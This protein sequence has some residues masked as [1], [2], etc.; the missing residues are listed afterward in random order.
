MDDHPSITKS[1]GLEQNSQM[2]RNWPWQN[3]RKRKESNIWCKWAVYSQEKGQETWAT[4]VHFTF[5][6]LQIQL[7]FSSSVDKRVKIWREE[8]VLHHWYYLHLEESISNEEVFS[9]LP[10]LT[11]FSSLFALKFGWVYGQARPWGGDRQCNRI[12]LFLPC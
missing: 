4:C 3:F 7:T 2:G 1:S 5:P 11:T 10:P 9:V 8:S 6:K 12:N